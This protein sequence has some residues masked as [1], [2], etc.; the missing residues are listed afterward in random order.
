MSKFIFL[1]ALFLST[2][3][4]SGCAQSKYMTFEDYHDVAIGQSIADI[5]VQMGRPYEVTG[6]SEKQQEY[7]YIER[8]SIG[9][10]RE[11]FRKYILIVEDGKVVDKRVKEES[12]SPVQFTN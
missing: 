3:A 9:E 7:I 4:L 10:G 11:F 8:F 12:S 6:L 1:H 2:I 5:Q